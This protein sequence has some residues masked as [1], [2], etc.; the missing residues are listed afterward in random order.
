MQVQSP[1]EGE[2]RIQYM[3]HLCSGD[4]LDFFTEIIFGKIARAD[5]PRWHS[6]YVARIWEY[7]GHGT[8][9]APTQPAAETERAKWHT[10][11]LT[12][13]GTTS[14]TQNYLVADGK[15]IPIGPSHTVRFN[16]TPSNS[17]WT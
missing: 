8:Y 4:Y 14:K 13:D 11:V 5:A 9:L 10:V 15:W 3:V 1:F 7:S 6:A 12:H 16:H 2:G 17:K